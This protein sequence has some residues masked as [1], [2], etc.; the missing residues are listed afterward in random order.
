MTIGQMSGI[1]ISQRK[2]S[3]VNF[4][5]IIQYFQQLAIG[6]KSWTCYWGTS[7]ITFIILMIQRFII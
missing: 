2:N 4:M 3:L 5:S 6:M 1:I 7:R